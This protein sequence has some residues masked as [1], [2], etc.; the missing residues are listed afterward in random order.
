MPRIYRVFDWATIVHFLQRTV[1][2]GYMARLLSVVY[3]VDAFEKIFKMT[4][5]MLGNYPDVFMMLLDL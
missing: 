4:Y 1:S 5:D 2:E 3:G